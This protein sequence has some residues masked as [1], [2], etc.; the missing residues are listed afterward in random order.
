MRRRA[1]AVT[2]A[3]VVAVVLA[4]CGRAEAPGVTEG[5][6][7]TGAESGAK[8]ELRFLAMEYDTNT[9]PFMQKV[10]REFEA[11]N[12]DVDLSIE[13]IDWQNGFQ[14][15]STLISAENA[16]DMA[17]IA[18]IWLPEL[19]DLDVVQPLDQFAG[20][21]FLDRFVPKALRGA[22]YQDTLYG[23]PIAMSAR[24]LY[25]NTDLVAEPPKT[26]DELVQ[27]GRRAT[28]RANGIF[29]F[30]VQGRETETDVYFYYFLWANGGQILSEDGTRAAF[31]GPAG[32]EALQFMVDLRG[33]G[34]CLRR[35]CPISTTSWRRS[36]RT[37]N[38]SRWR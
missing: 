17:N 19:V 16:P 23:L 33:S 36:P 37:G 11:A 29:G 22:T 38:R 7:D 31:N 30:G 3:A 35:K 32:V 1:M 10:E 14:K 28:D 6:M 4:G 2:M 18:T 24:A 9:R 26:W 34:G 5:G 21:D 12:P 25:C 8:T 20:E 13:V 15:L 27:V